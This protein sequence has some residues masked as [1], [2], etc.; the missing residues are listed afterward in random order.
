MAELLREFYGFCSADFLNTVLYFS[1]VEGLYLLVICR[2][3]W[4]PFQHLLYEII[5]IKK[6]LIGY[7]D[8]VSIQKI[9]FHSHDG[10]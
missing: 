9:V 4:V 10:T 1:P 7:Y 6:V 5:L 8:D 3:H 2:G